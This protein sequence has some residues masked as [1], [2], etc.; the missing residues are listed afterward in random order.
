MST[1][2]YMQPSYIEK[3]PVSTW[4]Y[5]V[6]LL[7]KHCTAARDQGVGPDA[8]RKRYSQPFPFQSHQISFLAFLIFL[9]D[10]V[11]VTLDEHGW[12]FLYKSPRGPLGGVWGP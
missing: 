2:I 11:H 7:L 1:D 3:Y 5:G 12:A 9:Y 4:G 10:S 6:A 8:K